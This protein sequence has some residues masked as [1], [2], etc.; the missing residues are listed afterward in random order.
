[1]IRALFP[2]AFLAG[3]VTE[4]GNPELVVE[5]RATASTTS[6]RVTVAAVPGLVVESAWV[7]IDEVRLV[8]SG[9]CGG[10]TEVDHAVSG[11]FPTDLLAV[12]VD[13]IQL[14]APP[15]DYC[16]LRVDLDAGADGGAVLG[17]DTVVVLGSRADGVPFAIRSVRGFDLELRGRGGAFTVDEARRG[18]LLDFDMDIWIGDIGLQYATPGDDGTIRV[19]DD[20]EPAILDAFEAATGAAL[21]LFGDDDRDGDRDDDDERLDDDHDGEDDDEDD[22]SGDDRERSDDED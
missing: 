3:C 9:G 11:P 2:V 19:D 14:D 18:F 20:H 22:D 21:G 13:P 16:R 17:T 12:T 7:S 15:A 10:G 8:E 1:M 6:E 4:T 5:L